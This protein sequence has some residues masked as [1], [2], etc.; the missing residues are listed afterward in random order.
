[1]KCEKYWPDIGSTKMYS[2]MTIKCT[3][4]SVQGNHILRE[5]HVSKG[6]VSVIFEHLQ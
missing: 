4:E 6:N 3:G 2:D 1:M 5:L